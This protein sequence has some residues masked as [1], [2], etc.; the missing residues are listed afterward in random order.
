[1]VIQNNNKTVS[2][3]L[4]DLELLVPSS[5]WYCV[6]HF[7]NLVLYFANYFILYLNW[8]RFEP[9]TSRLFN[10]KTRT[11]ALKIVLFFSA[12]KTFDNKFHE[13]Q[14]F[15]KILQSRRSKSHIFVDLI[16]RKRLNKEW[17]KVKDGKSGLC[18]VKNNSFEKSK[19]F[20]FNFSP[21]CHSF[22]G[23]ARRASKRRRQL[24]K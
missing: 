20:F 19:L 21:W 13:K 16:E 10:L 14:K 3:V 5:Y 1:L 24:P 12:Q 17:V 11:K 23:K 22:H 15:E 6:V 18:Q 2:V 7:S 4:N 8:A 9:V